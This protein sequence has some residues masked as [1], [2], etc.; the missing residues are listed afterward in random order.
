MSLLVSRMNPHFTFN[1][2][3]SIQSYILK[4]EKEQAIKYLSDFGSLIRKTLDY[5]YIDYIKISEEVSF[6]NLWVSLEN[7]RFA[8]GYSLSVTHKEETLDSKIPALL[9]QPII[10]NVF[11]HAIYPQSDQKLI[12]ININEEKHYLVLTVEDGGISKTKKD[13]Q[14]NHNSVGLKIVKDRIKQ[15]NGNDFE[16]QDFSITK[17]TLTAN[18]GFKVTIKLLKK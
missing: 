8:Q 10:E 14:E 15:H 4:N 6:L 9:L 16:N 12:H 11:K 5:S 13:Q 2:I 17:N 7:K 18:T 3:S 1:T